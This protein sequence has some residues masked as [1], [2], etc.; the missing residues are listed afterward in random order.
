MSGLLKLSKELYFYHQD[1]SFDVEKRSELYSIFKDLF[2]QV[3]L[4]LNM[5]KA[6]E[7]IRYINYEIL[8][9]NDDLFEHFKKKVMKTELQAKKVTNANVDEI[10]NR[11][12]A[13]LQSDKSVN[14]DILVIEQ[15]KQF[16]NLQANQVSIWNEEGGDKMFR[17]DSEKFMETDDE[18]KTYSEL[19]DIEDRFRDIDSQSSVSDHPSI[20][21]FD[22]EIV[23]VPE[24]ERY[25][26]GKERLKLD[27][28]DLQNEDEE[29][30]EPE[31]QSRFIQDMNLKEQEKLKRNQKFKQNLLNYNGRYDMRHNYKRF[32]TKNEWENDFDGLDYIFDK[33][34]YEFPIFGLNETY[35]KAISNVLSIKVNQILLYK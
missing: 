19:F 16:Y 20:D 14:Y 7:L 29:E 17:N 3:I 8:K 10:V 31:Q 34:L 27:I 4:A 22:K 25:S 2:Q 5:M 13:L 35:I 30:Q 21:S 1:H 18:Y 12:I 23:P 11:C 15:L 6:N 26:N 33:S 28:M 9:N 32:L 24:D